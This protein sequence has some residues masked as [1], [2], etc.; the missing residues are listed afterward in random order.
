MA[1]LLNA[2]LCVSLAA[3]AAAYQVPPPP[4]K[5]LL[6]TA[7][8]TAPVSPLKKLFTDVPEAISGAMSLLQRADARPAWIDSACEDS[9]GAVPRGMFSKGSK[10]VSTRPL[11]YVQKFCEAGGRAS[12]RA[13]RA[14]ERASERRETPCVQR[15]TA[16]VLVRSGALNYLSSVLSRAS[17]GRRHELSR[18]SSR[19][20]SRALAREPRAKARAREPKGHF[21]CSQGDLACSRA[22]AKGNGA[23]ARAEKYFRF[24]TARAR[25]PKNTSRGLRETSR[26]LARSRRP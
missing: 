1:P 16:R 24:P 26:V 8:K 9:A 13:T 7:S 11:R 23:S 10:P 4:D 22:R 19:E 17:Q 21:A 3:V 5:N 15:E 18:A 14:G 2:L 25:E 6:Q 20:T 12:E